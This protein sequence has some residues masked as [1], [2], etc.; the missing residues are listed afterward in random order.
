MI[1]IIIFFKYFQLCHHF[2][3]LFLNY[4][5]FLVFLQFFSLMVICFYFYFFY[6]LCICLLRLIKRMFLKPLHKQLLKYLLTFHL[7]YC[8]MCLVQQYSHEATNGN[9]GETMPWK[10]DADRPIF[11]QLVELLQMDILS[12]K[13]KPGDKISAVRD[14]AQEAAVNPNTMQKALTEL[15]RLGLVYTERTS[16][17]FVTKDEN[18]IMNLKK[19]QY[20]RCVI[21]VIF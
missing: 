16:G 17:R 15:E 21:Q 9:G 19:E 14:L 8:I 1:L 10:L 4:F 12:G 6:H 13:Y 20:M 18:L 3:L 7:Y 11:I 2:Q 5:L